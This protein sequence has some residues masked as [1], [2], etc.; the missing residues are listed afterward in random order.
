MYKTSLL[1]TTIPIFQF[2]FDVIERNKIQIL[3]PWI[4]LLETARTDLLCLKLLTESM[5]ISVCVCVWHLTWIKWKRSQMENER[6]GYKSYEKKTVVLHFVQ[7]SISNGKI[8]MNTWARQLVLT[9]NI[10]CEHFAVECKQIWKF[11][12][13]SVS[14]LSFILFIHFLLGFSMPASHFNAVNGN[15]WKFHCSWVK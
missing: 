15:P 3:L 5:S 8:G 1:L 12:F 14:N 7:F 6:K 2:R 10:K 11:Y 13:D 4:F 9:F